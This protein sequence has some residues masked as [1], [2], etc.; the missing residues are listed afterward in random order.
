M[1][2]CP[3]PT[4][5]RDSGQRSLTSSTNGARRTAATQDAARAARSCG[6]VPTTTSGRRSRSEAGTADVMKLR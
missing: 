2:P 5:T 4:A 6:E 1:R 3:A